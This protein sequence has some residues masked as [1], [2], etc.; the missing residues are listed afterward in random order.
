M[1]CNKEI[2]VNAH[3]LAVSTKEKIEK[4]ASTTILLPK[5]VF[6]AYSDIRYNP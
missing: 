2:E 3:K 5:Q 6:I 4:R 1:E